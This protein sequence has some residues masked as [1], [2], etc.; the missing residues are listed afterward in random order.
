MTFISTLPRPGAALALIALWAAMTASSLVRAESTEA[1]AWLEVAYPALVRGD[2]VGAVQ[3]FAKACAA[4]PKS[5]GCISAGQSLGAG[6][7]VV[8]DVP[9]ALA[10]L[11]RSCSAGIS[12]GCDELATLR[13]AHGGSARSGTAQT[14]SSQKSSNL[15]RS[16]PSAS[17]TVPATRSLTERC[18][19]GDGYACERHGW[20]MGNTGSWLVAAQ[21]AKRGCAMGR[22][23]SCTA[24][25]MYELNYRNHGDQSQ[26][27]MLARRAS[28]IDQANANGTHSR[29]ISEHLQAERYLGTLAGLIAA[30]GPAALQR[31]SFDDV[32]DLANQD[33]EPGFEVAGNYVRTEWQRRG[34]AAE[35]AARQRAYAAQREQPRTFQGVGDN[36]N[37]TAECYVGGR[38]GRRYQYS[39]ANGRMVYGPCT[40]L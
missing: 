12:Q 23:T 10:L 29:A 40:A 5:V 25:E 34:G 30:G 14:G 2:K 38:P 27:G 35:L 4:D 11:E 3:A 19:S 6:N 20:D 13:S 15:A 8:Q 21:Y 22:P 28:I 24:Q 16:L 31:L 33:W 32:A 26:A 1:D 36:E 18:D 17:P 7:G 37:G 39:G 9:R